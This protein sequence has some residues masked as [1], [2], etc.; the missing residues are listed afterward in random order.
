MRDVADGPVVV[1]TGKGGNGRGGLARVRHL[2]HR[3]L[4][5]N[6]YWT[7]LRIVTG[8]A[9]S[10]YGVLEKVTVSADVGT[11]ARAN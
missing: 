11:E 5:V 2:S 10:Q 8:A 4:P 3:N 9:A 1:V 6:V 7:G